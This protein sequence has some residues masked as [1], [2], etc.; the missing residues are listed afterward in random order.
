MIRSGM[1]VW[2][3]ESAIAIGDSTAERMA[4]IKAFSAE[5]DA[6]SA[7]KTRQ[8]QESRAYPIP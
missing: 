3:I 4:A 6:G 8:N 5:V 2:I 1:P 7:Q